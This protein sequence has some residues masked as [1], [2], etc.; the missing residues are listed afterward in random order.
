MTSF[1]RTVYQG[2][3]NEF[4]IDTRLLD[5]DFE[6]LRSVAKKALDEQTEKLEMVLNPE[7]KFMYKVVAWKDSE[8]VFVSLNR[9]VDNFVEWL[10]VPLSIEDYIH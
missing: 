10:P 6:D 7:N 8:G 1:Y 4:F 3:M 9:D 2:D 5:F